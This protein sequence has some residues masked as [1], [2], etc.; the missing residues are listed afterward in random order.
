MVLKAR[1]RGRR[2]SLGVGLA[3]KACRRFLLV[4]SIRLIRLRR[5]AGIGSTF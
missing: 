4:L 2:L 3:R 5:E 1:G